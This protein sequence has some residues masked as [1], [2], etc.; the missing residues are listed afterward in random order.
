MEW[1]FLSVAGAVFL[2]YYSLSF[3][4]QI[5]HGIRA[6]VLPALGIK[7]NLKKLG[8]WAGKLYKVTHAARSTVQSSIDSVF[9]LIKSLPESP[10]CENLNRCILQLSNF[11]QET[12]KCEMSFI[13]AKEI[14]VLSHACVEL[15]NRGFQARFLDS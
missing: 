10:L 4:L 3:I 15:L 5:L 6:F 7:K 8:Q 13:C 9:F 1:N 14:H 12:L 11:D 2:G